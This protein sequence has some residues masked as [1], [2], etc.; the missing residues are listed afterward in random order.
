MKV[1][2][3]VEKLIENS[4]NSTGSRMLRIISICHD[5]HGMGKIEEKGKQ[6]KDEKKKS[7]I[8]IGKNDNDEKMIEETDEEHIGPL[9]KKSKGEDINKVNDNSEFSS[10]GD[11]THSRI[12]NSV[13]NIYDNK[14]KNTHNNGDSM[15]VRWTRCLITIEKIEI[16]TADTSND[17]VHNIS[18]NP[19][20]DDKN[21]ICLPNIFYDRRNEKCSISSKE[22]DDFLFPGFRKELFKATWRGGEK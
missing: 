11:I 3:L 15:N 4:A 5:D 12:L 10:D 22:F 2:D 8:K 17:I 20:N 16:E 14:S 19:K 18:K 13:A 7:S 6:K 9:K 21:S 1:H